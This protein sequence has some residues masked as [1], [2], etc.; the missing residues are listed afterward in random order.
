VADLSD[1]RRLVRDTKDLG[2]G[3]TLR[4]TEADWRAF[5]AGVKNGQFD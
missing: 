4:F 5:V 2:H 3:P 1:G